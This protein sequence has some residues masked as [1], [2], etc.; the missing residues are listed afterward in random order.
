ML[1]QSMNSITEQAEGKKQAASCCGLLQL[2]VTLY[3]L[4]MPCPRDRPSTQ[5]VHLYTEISVCEVSTG[6]SSLA[7]LPFIRSTI[8]LDPRTLHARR[9]PRT[10]QTCVEHKRASQMPAY[11]SAP[12]KLAATEDMPANAQTRNTAITRH[13][14]RTIGCAPA[15]D[16]MRS[17]KRLHDN[18]HE[19]LQAIRIAPLVVVPCDTAQHA[20]LIALAFGGDNLRHRRVEDR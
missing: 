8:P 15:S 17:R 19:I 11:P 6:G 16:R 10:G 4:A 12:A 18:L 2:V 5:T 20:A 13:A 9:T 7:V 14:S 1:A 3:L